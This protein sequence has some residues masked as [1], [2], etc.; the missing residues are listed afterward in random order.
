MGGGLTFRVKKK[1][2]FECRSI[3]IQYLK[4]VDVMRA[5]LE[6][7]TRPLRAEAFLTVGEY[8][9]DMFGD[10]NSYTPNQIRMRL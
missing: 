3:K 9:Q 5:R 1:K 7:L 4:Q 2:S 10:P 6:N 8:Y